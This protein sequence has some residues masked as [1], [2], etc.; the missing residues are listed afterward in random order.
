M[1]SEVAMPKIHLMQTEGPTRTRALRLFKLEDA[2]SAIIWVSYAGL[3]STA[4]A[5][6]SW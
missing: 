1:Q 5:I 3:V 2:T 4:V 6:M